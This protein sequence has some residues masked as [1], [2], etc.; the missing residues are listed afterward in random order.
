MKIGSDD[1]REK[2]NL[3]SGEGDKHAT[4]KRERE[5]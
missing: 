3:A 4:V 1:S 5:I 2:Q